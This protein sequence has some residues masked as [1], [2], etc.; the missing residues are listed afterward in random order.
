M[1]TT[2]QDYFHGGLHVRSAKTS[3]DLTTLSTTLHGVAT[4][5]KNTTG[6][7]EVPPLPRYP[8]AREESKRASMPYGAAEK[9]D[10]V[11]Q[12]GCATCWGAAGNNIKRCMQ[13]FVYLAISLGGG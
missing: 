13:S 8:S 1:A 10:A 12:G 4:A 3:S 7:N 2:Q 5:H 11:H 6:A 9:S